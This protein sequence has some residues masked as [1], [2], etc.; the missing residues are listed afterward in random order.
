MKINTIA[1]LPAQNQAY[2]SNYT[3]KINSNKIPLNK[4]YPE[5]EF[6]YFP[7]NNTSSTIT[8]TFA[9]TAG[10]GTT[11]YIVIVGGSYNNNGSSGNT[12]TPLNASN[13]DAFPPVITSK[14][15][16]NFTAVFT[17]S[18]GDIWNGGFQFIVIYY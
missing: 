2:S 14:T 8:N 1:L 7:I 12:Y 11:D 13:A 3:V 15:T 4:Y 17:K 5:C 9:L 10:K 6:F 18:T 16:S